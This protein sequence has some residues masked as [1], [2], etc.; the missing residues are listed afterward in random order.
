MLNDK[1]NVYD[2]AG[3]GIGPFNLGLAALTENIPELNTLF[4][5]QKPF[6]MW[7]SGLLIEQTKLQVPFLADLVSMADPTSPFGFLNYLKE[8]GRLYRF[9]FYEQFHISRNEYNHYCQWV[10]NQLASCRFGKKVTD[11]H[12]V[13]NDWGETV[14]ELFVE[15]INTNGGQ[16]TYYAKNLALG[17]GSLPTIPVSLP[18]NSDQDC[19]HSADFLNHI[20]RLHRAQSITIVG[21]GQSAAEVFYELLKEQREKG[22]ELNWL[23]RSTGFFPMEYSKLGLEHFSPDYMNYFYQ[24]ASYKKAKRL[25]K[26]WLLYKGISYDTIGE[27]Y[28]LMYER[29][30]GVDHLPT[31]LQAM[32]EVKEVAKTTNDKNYTLLCYQWEQEKSFTL[33]TECVLFATGYQ[34]NIPTCI[35]HILPLLKLDD[36]GR[37]KVTS[38]FQVE[39][40]T[41]FDNTVFVQNAELHTHGVG[42]PDLGLGAYRNSVIINTLMNEEVYSVSQ[43]SVFQNFGI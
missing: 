26:Q 43:S 23:T 1:N 2:L 16:E 15:D 42:S 10:T 4:L 39:M 27:I 30:I 9:Y 31:Y 29:S 18:I 11:I 33:E 25:S 40:T 24:L 5:D 38:D 22:Y 37:Y 13:T 12:H 7:H 36:Q 34:Y 6:Y 8:Q 17:I 14:F 28:D 32:T 20:D 19:F 3:V 41:D 35:R 21:S